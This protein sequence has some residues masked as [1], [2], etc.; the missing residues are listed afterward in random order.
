M[1]ILKKNSV[2]N[3]N[4]FYWKISKIILIKLSEILKLNEN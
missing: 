4:Q 1:H 3:L 2:L